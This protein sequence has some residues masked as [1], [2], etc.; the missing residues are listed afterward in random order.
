[1]TASTINELLLIKLSVSFSKVPIFSLSHN[2]S[3]N[4][5]GDISRK[6]N[7]NNYEEGCLFFHFLFFLLSRGTKLEI[8]PR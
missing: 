8:I 3:M 6:K 2:S 4:S 5:L 7:I 1:M